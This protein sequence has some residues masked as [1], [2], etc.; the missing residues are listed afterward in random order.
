MLHFG[1]YLF[2]RQNFVKKRLRFRCELRQV[3]K[4]KMVCQRVKDFFEGS[5]PRIMSKEGQGKEEMGDLFKKKEGLWRFIFGS[6]G[7][8]PSNLLGSYSGLMYDSRTCDSVVIHLA[9][10]LA[11]T[12]YFN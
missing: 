10:L 6:G 7:R 1:I 5:I 12:L 9:N 8:R 4:E 11:S 2:H 3:L